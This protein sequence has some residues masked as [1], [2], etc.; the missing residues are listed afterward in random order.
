MDSKQTDNS[1]APLA[2]WQFKH[3]TKE[4]CGL[5]GM[6]L[7]DCW[8]R[9]SACG[10]DSPKDQPY[11][12]DDER[13]RERCSSCEYFRYRN[14]SVKDV[15]ILKELPTQEISCSIRLLAP[16]SHWLMPSDFSG[17]FNLLQNKGKVTAERIHE[18][19]VIISL[20]VVAS[21]C[22]LLQVIISIASKMLLTRQKRPPKPQR[23]FEVIIK[24]GRE[25]EEIF[26]H[27][28]MERLLRLL[29]SEVPPKRITLQL[30]DR[31]RGS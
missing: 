9:V 7:A 15:A 6:P 23:T 4:F 17:L 14:S 13:R 21:A 22:T 27:C 26:P 5:Y 31:A 24:W 10:V 16:P 29:E 25:T 30:K 1:E 28:T 2:C 18:N 20:T 3:C 8:L 12:V 11:P 19:E